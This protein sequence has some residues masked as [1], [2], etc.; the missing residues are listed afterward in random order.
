[1]F[2]CY[3]GSAWKVQTKG[4][5]RV[6]PSEFSHVVN[7]A[8]NVCNKKEPRAGDFGDFVIRLQASQA[9]GRSAGWLDGMESRELVAPLHQ[10]RG[11][12]TKNNP[13]G[14]H[15]IHS[16]SSYGQA[17]TGSWPSRMPGHPEGESA[18][19]TQRGLTRKLRSPV[20]AEPSKSFLLSVFCVLLFS[21]SHAPSRLALSLQLCYCPDQ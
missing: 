15:P 13:R 19:D 9:K 21:V 4:L 17:C 12:W 2:S 1:M 7:I 6:A 3:S 18:R 16:H 8:N 10:Q 20:R 11:A 5:H 14:C